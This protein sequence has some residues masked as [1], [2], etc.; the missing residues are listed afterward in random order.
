M[1]KPRTS[2]SR[3]IFGILGSVPNR[4]HVQRAWNE[5]FQSHQMDAFM[6]HYPT[7]EKLLP[8]RLS[9]MFHFDRR[10]YIVSSRLSE[11]VVPLLDRLDGSA[12]RAQRVNTVFNE[13]GILIG[14]WI[15]GDDSVH[16][17]L[18]VWNLI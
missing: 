17:R 4:S 9:E 15:E 18:S 10:G 13:G 7:V 12:Q 8:E 6:D 1:T 5:Y 16:G 3:E 2:V 11:A 14:F